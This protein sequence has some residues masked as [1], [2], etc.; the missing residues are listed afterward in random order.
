MAYT[1]DPYRNPHDAQD[2][3]NGWAHHEKVRKERERQK[4]A[5]K[6]KRGKQTKKRRR[7]WF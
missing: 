7:S 2:Y 4:A 5:A 3:V 1:Y 6:A